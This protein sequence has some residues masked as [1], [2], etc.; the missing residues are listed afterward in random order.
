MLRE[1]VK[2]YFQHKTYCKLRKRLVVELCP[3]IRF[4]DATSCRWFAYFVLLFHF[5]PNSVN[6][7]TCNVSINVTVRRVYVTNFTRNKK[8][9]LNILSVYVC[10]LS[11]PKCNRHA[12]YCRLWPLPLYHTF[13]RYLISGTI[14]GLKNVT[15]YKMC[16]LIFST[17]FVR[18]IF[19]SKKNWARYDH[20]CT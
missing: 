8:Q 10:S 13:P 16:V 18:K 9:V 11:Y 6:N 19:Y 20:K 12:P 2:C 3:C 4:A 1:R 15:G 17:T 7:K 14:F 5:V